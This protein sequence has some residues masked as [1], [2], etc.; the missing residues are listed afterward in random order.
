MA[1]KFV[2]VVRLQFR[3]GELRVCGQTFFRKKTIVGDPEPE[4]DPEPD[5]QD[6]HVFEPPGSGSI[7]Q[8]PSRFS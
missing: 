4:P 3:S 5:P 8:A 2:S 7:N 6:P 1:L